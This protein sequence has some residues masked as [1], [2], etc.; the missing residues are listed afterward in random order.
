M[1]ITPKEFLALFDGVSDVIR[2][3]LSH[4]AIAELTP[5]ALIHVTMNNGIQYYLAATDS[6]RRYFDEYYIGAILAM[7]DRY[8]DD[9]NIN[10]YGVCIHSDAVAFCDK[11]GSNMIST[12]SGDWSDIFYIDDTD[13]Q[14]IQHFMKTTKNDA[15]SFQS[16]WNQFLSM[17]GE[18]KIVDGAVTF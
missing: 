16:K 5:G 8:Q 2:P 13:D 17:M 12:V 10:L 1:N 9:N 4:Y 6:Y 3:Q 15:V 7:R 11:L 18:L 14:L